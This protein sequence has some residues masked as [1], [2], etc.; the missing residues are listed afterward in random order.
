VE[1][2]SGGEAAAGDKRNIRRE[3]I[4]VAEGMC[5]ARFV[6]LLWILAPVTCATTDQRYP[7]TEREFLLP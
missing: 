5:K 1:Y 7:T 2:R 4:T 3:M 6:L